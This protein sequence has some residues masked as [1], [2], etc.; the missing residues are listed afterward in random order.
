MRSGT[1]TEDNKTHILNNEVGGHGKTLGT[2]VMSLFLRI[3]K[4]LYVISMLN[5]Y[6]WACIL[7]PS[8]CP[9]AISELSLLYCAFRAGSY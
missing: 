6:T 8:R 7:S 4:L 2:I 3:L 1:S 5:R 9:A